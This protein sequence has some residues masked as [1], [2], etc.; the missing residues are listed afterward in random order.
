MADDE[1]Q[2]SSAQ[3][4]RQNRL[5]DSLRENLKRRKSQSR[6]RAD[7]PAGG[8]SVAEA[9]AAPGKGTRPIDPDRES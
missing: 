8:H 6:G 9:A 1:K 5:R 4:A 2:R 3:V 7:P